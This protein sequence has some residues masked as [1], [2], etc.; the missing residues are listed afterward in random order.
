MHAPRGFAGELIV[1]VLN[2]LEN[3]PM[4]PK[5]A[6]KI[7][8]ADVETIRDMLEC[9]FSQGRVARNR[10]IPKVERNGTRACIYSIRE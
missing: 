1:K 10:F 5:T 4:T 8:G 6:S 2:L 3:G 9:L 7:T